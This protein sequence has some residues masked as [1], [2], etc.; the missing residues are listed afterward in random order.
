[1]E[2]LALSNISPLFVDRYG[3]SLRFCHLE[4]NYEDISDGSRSK[5]AGSGGGDFNF[6]CF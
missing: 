2:R 1:M 3:R 6:K 5:S 4:F